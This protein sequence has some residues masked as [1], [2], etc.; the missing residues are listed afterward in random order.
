MDINAPEGPTRS[1]KDFAIHILIVTI[2]ILIAL[3]LEGIRESVHEDNSL[4]E[5]RKT[6]SKELGGDR[7][8]LTEETAN[9]RDMSAQLDGV[10]RDYTELV[11]SPDQ[12]QKRIDD[13]HP[14][15]YYFAERP[16]ALQV[17]AES[18]HT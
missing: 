14:A 8:N 4:V 12:L 18:W 2:G 17:P 6:F 10:L 1:F 11:K 5:T 16:G 9:V 13:I 3:G 15:F 7:K